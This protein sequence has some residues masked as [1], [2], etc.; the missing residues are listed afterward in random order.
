MT[1][2][3]LGIETGSFDTTFCCRLADKLRLRLVDMRDV[4]RDAAE[5]GKRADGVL[6]RLI[7]HRALDKGRR[8]PECRQVSSRVG[9]ELIR[10]AAMDNVLIVGWCA[11]AILRPVTHAIRIRIIAPLAWRERKLA[12]QLAYRDVRTARL[13]IESSDALIERF[14]MHTTST[15]WRDPSLY[16]LTLNAEALTAE[17]CATFLQ[18]LAQ[19]SQFRQ[20]AET[21]EELCGILQGLHQRNRVR[22]DEGIGRHLVAVVD[23]HEVA[24]SQNETNESAIAKIERYLQGQCKPFDIDDPR[25]Y[26]QGRS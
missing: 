12:V 26:C 2:I 15:D 7:R 16:H 24:L 19:S 20:T 8:R 6:N 23:G 11:C 17:M 4:E 13:E 5:R 18:S 21:R 25:R 1:V 22:P 3:A 9:E 14:V 10:S